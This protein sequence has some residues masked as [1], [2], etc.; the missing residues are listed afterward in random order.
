MVN[1]TISAIA[2]LSEAER[3]GATITIIDGPGLGSTAVVDRADGVVAGDRGDWLFDEMLTDTDALMDREESRSLIYGDRRVF[4]DTIAPRPTM[5][6]FGA[7]HIA[8]PLSV[9]AGELGFRV[10]V[11]D[12]RAAWATQERFPDVDELI[13]AWPGSVFDH[14]E[15]DSKTYV[16]MLSHDAR[17]EIPVFEAVHGT[18]IKY[19]G[20]MGSRRTHVMRV[21]R[22]R[23]E[24]W[25][26]E[27]IDSIHGPIGLDLKGRTPAETAVAIAGEVIL[28]R[29]GG[30]SALSL[31]GTD[32][33][34]H[35]T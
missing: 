9:I 34:I 12:A 4:I 14:I 35:G 31:S 19:L 5:L 29:Y 13:V 32:V 7:G 17:F 33:A 3:L 8:Q 2:H 6:I 16:V 24:G 25:T 21:E 23:A 10:V 30:G 22:L 26:D 11:A 15:P 28:V 20:A 27:Q 1:S 18:P